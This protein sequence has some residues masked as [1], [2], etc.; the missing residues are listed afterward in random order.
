MAVDAM[1]QG[2]RCQTCLA[3]LLSAVQRSVDAIASTQDIDGLTWA[4]PLGHVKYLMDQAEVGGGLRSAERLA[5]AL[6]D[7]AL[8]KKVHDMRTRHDRGLTEMLGNENEPMV[9]AISESDA[10]ARTFGLPSA[11]VVVD[12]QKLYPD[13]L[14]P[15]FVGALVPDLAPHIIR[16]AV[17]RYNSVWW[18]WDQDPDTW[19]F[20]VLVAW[21]LR[22]SGD[23]M[24]A[25]KGARA[26]HQWIVEGYRGNALTVG[27][28]GQLMAFA[29]EKGT[30]G[31]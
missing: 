11:R 13:A 20:P 14:G 30:L 31:R 28:V 16:P 24:A 17:A 1:Y 12:E 26:L 27:H 9:W 22:Q 10:V 4:Q 5:N 19:G 21:A 15:I 6:G 29:Y 18:R 23:E 25:T 2:D 7:A 8:L 3:A